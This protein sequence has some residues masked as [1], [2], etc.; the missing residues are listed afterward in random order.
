MEGEKRG[1]LAHDDIGGSDTGGQGVSI[2]L[3][4]GLCEYYVFL[5]TSS[6][7]G[8]SSLGLSSFLVSV[9]NILRSNEFLILCM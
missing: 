2:G 7:G 3:S 8:G 4:L 1:N 6:G 5:G 9:M